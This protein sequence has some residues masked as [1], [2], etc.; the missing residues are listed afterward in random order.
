MAYK[1]NIDKA[2]EVAQA[3]EGGGNYWAVAEGRNRIRILPPWSEEAAEAGRYFFET[4]FHYGIGPDDRTM[5][6]PL[7]AGVRDTCFLCS[8][9][10]SLKKSS[11][12]D[13]QAEAKDLFPKRKYLMN[14]VDIAHP[15]KGVQVWSAGVKAMRQVHYYV[16]DREYGDITDLEDGYDLIVEKTGSGINTEYFVKAAKRSSSFPSDEL[17]QKNP[18][19]ADIDKEGALTDLATFLDYPSDAEMQSVYEG[20][21]KATAKAAEEDEEEEEEEAP[22]RT[23]LRHLARGRAGAAPARGHGPRFPDE[24]E[25]EE[26]PEEEEEQEAPAARPARRTESASRRVSR[27]LRTR[28]GK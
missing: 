20:T 8:L 26:E 17:V 2:D 19:L 4:A 27:A 12:E 5:P 10:N 28:A 23:S 25:P 3:L 24:E 11:D 1:L 9:A 13:D 22:R 14:I 6:C 15:E 18:L 7:A 21:G 16:R